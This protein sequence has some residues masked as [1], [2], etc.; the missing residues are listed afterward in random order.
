LHGVPTD[1]TVYQ[2]E[3]SEVSNTRPTTAGTQRRVIANGAVTDR[4]VLYVFAAT[5]RKGI[6]RPGHAYVKTLIDGGVPVLAASKLVGHS[7]SKT[8]ER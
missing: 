6:G 7:D 5:G 3:R 4:Q 8:T 1:R 2:D